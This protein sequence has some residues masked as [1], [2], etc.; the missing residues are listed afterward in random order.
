M[1]D[2]NATTQVLSIEVKYNDGNAGQKIRALKD[3]IEAIDS[4]SRGQ[5]FQ[6]LKSVADSMSALGQAASSIKGVGPAFQQVAQSA[7]NLFNTFKSFNPKSYASNISALTGALSSVGKSLGDF[8]KNGSGL[9]S[10]NNALSKLPTAVNQF[11]NVNP[12]NIAN[13]AGTM[14]QLANATESAAKKGE[15]L[16]NFRIGLE[17][18]PAALTQY[19]DAA[20]KAMSGFSGNVGTVMSNMSKSLSGINTNAFN[21]VDKLA[22]GLERLSKLSQD[23]NLQQNLQN[24]AQQIASFAQSV[25]NNIS[26]DTLS[27]FERLGSAMA[28][29]SS[30]SGKSFN[31]AS[32]SNGAKTASKAFDVL[33]ASIKKTVKLGWQLGKLPFKMILSPIQSIGRGIQG[34]TQRFTTFLSSI[35]RIALYRAIRA[36]IKLVT[37]AVREGVNNLYVWADM[38]GNSFKPTMDSLATS[39]LY[40]KNSI[41]AM[42]SPLL[43]ALAP[44]LET[45]VNQIVDVLNIF[46]QVIATMTG[47]STWRKA[48]RTPATYADSISNIGSSAADATDSVKELKR[49]IL[50]FDEIN[51]LDDASKIAA[52]TTSGG[53]PSGANATQGA[54]SFTEETIGKTALDI[55]K[56]LKDAWAKAD[57]TEIGE[58]VAKK[59]AGALNSIDWSRVK[60]MTQKLAKSIGTFL[61]G[62]LDYNGEGGK[63]LWNAVAKT[64]YNGI[65]TA[66][67][68]Y[69]TFFDTVNWKGIGNG[70]GAALAKVCRNIN[71]T[72]GKNSVGDALAAFPN[73]VIDTLTGFTQKFTFNNFQK[74]GSNIG[75]AVTKALTKIKWSGLFN[76]AV[77]IGTGIL[78]A[79]NGFLTNLD[80]SGIKTAILNGIKSIP[81]KKWSDLGTQIGNAI[82]NIASFLA[83]L[84]DT[85]IKAIEAVKWGDIA[86]A[87][88]SSLDKRVKAQGGWAGVAKNV[89]G[90]FKDHI[91][92]ISAVLTLAIGSFVLKNLTANFAKTMMA[93]IGAL[94]VPGAGMGLASWAKN[95]IILAASISLAIGGIK[96]LFGHDFKKSSIKDNLLTLL[97]GAGELGAAGAG[98]G[99]V[100]GGPAGAL[101][102]AVTGVIISLAIAGFKWDPFS[103]KTKKE[104]T[105]GLQNNIDQELS[106]AQAYLDANNLENQYYEDQVN[107]TVTST[108]NRTYGA[109]SGS[110]QKWNEVTVTLK[111]TVS[112][113]DTKTA[114]SQLSTWWSGITK[115]NKVA[116]F[117]TKGLLN[118]SKGW[119]TSL[120]TWWNGIVNNEKV[121]EF[122]SKGLNNQSA[123]W[124]T[125]LNTWWNSIVNS[126]KVKEFTTKGLSNKSDNWKTSLITWWNSIVRNYKVAEFAS[127]GLKNDSSSWYSSLS[128]YWSNIIQ[129][130]DKPSFSVRISDNSSSLWKALSSYW[131]V[132]TEGRALKAKVTA[133]ISN[134]NLNSVWTSISNFFKN[135]PITATV[136]TIVKK[137][138]SS[139]AIIGKA[140]G[141]V[142]KNGSWHPITSFAGGGN[143]LSGQ[144]FIAREAGPELV[145][146]IGGNTAVMNNDQ[147]V[148]SVANGVAK[149]VSSVLGGNG[150][151]NSNEIVIKVDSETLYRAVKKGEK[152]ASGR[153]GTVVVI[154]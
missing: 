32:M 103:E 80:W 64:I 7:E 31:G 12:Q 44:A 144:M 141:G 49:T 117:I 104:L 34:M 81:K 48:L 137:V 41:G 123:N 23:Q 40:L 2:G 92:T 11:G 110:G 136:K 10:L 55:A 132:Q 35:G 37:T 108:Q 101:I 131:N 89:A 36:G 73:A 109:S 67:L 3:D 105:E 82:F 28:G 154:G 56:M 140:E 30:G 91:G 39:F 66:V 16:N 63:A 122:T 145:G 71:W 102:G 135:N 88:K 59:I 8:A 68:G 47:A 98:I 74:L 24:I 76:S 142:Y 25:V 78:G 87:I 70:I 51:K 150:G 50:G 15:G 9:S 125:K 85:L 111:P 54:F 62:L 4:A 128:T 119:K 143:P 72:S 20:T 58:L 146:T 152:K 149:A 84:G 53:S 90:Y 19:S 17:K 33:S 1:A 42:V 27:R 129:K 127:K 60:T 5:G 106:S 52:P 148:A 26:D 139:T 21:A 134:N 151:G 14:D 83:N 147:I 138:T 124:K 77:D 126:S 94:T 29:L 130:K 118:G 13:I 57:F 120:I 18:F 153:Y 115:K 75:R 99:F 95:A 38:V 116:A 69:T 93:R 112:Q 97:K 114:W 61:N 46:N 86:K 22:S 6:H 113:A 107:G 96:T 121:K 133:N 100:F 79:L 45:V 65:N 43:D